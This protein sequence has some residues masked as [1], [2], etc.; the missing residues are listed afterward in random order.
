MG[1]S[2]SRWHSLIRVVLSPVIARYFPVPRHW[3]FTSTPW[4]SLSVRQVWLLA[5]P[6]QVGI[7]FYLRLAAGLLARRA[8]Q[9]HE[10]HGAGLRDRHGQGLAGHFRA[11][12]GDAESREERGFQG[13]G[14]I[15]AERPP[16][17][18]GL[19]PRGEADGAARL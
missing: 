14:Q 16:L 10:Q 18:R 13:R 8:V 3:N 7:A 17:G 12:R 5:P 6:E 9:P 15:R 1:W 19:A 11:R 4:L 2:G